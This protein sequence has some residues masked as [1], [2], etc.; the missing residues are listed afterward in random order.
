M[1]EEADE[2]E[3]VPSR[4]HR[5]AS[6]QSAEDL[7]LCKA[8]ISALEDAVVGTNQKSADFKNKFHANYSL[9]ITEYNDSYGTKYS[10]RTSVS[11]FNRFKKI[12]KYVLKFIGVKESNGPPPSGDTGREE[13]DKQVKQIFLARYPECANFVENIVGCKMF[14]EDKPKWKTYQEDEENTQE[15]RSKKSR[16]TGNKKAKER[17]ADTELVKKCLSV[18]ESS[19]ADSKKEHLEKKE[20]FM[21]KIGE[22]MDLLAT[23]FQRTLEEQN[24]L[25]FMRMLDENSR[26]RLAE[27][28]FNTKMARL[29]AEGQKYRK[30]S[31][32]ASVHSGITVEEIA[33]GNTTAAADDEEDDQQEFF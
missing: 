7:E 2:I 4:N 31:S 10:L 15:E 32:G 11:A 30:I 28:M 19:K 6:Y 25:K 20:A 5:G 3:V 29:K 1:S 26:K 13:F 18:A 22:S 14:L 12:S 9:L 33:F 24:D 8:F 27:E 21:M 23:A 17:K 16:P